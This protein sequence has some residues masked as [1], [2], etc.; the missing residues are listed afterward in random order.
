MRGWS[1]H[2]AGRRR[3]LPLEICDLHRWPLLRVALTHAADI[4]LVAQ[5]AAVA[6]P[7]SKAVLLTY[8]QPEANHNGGWLGFGKDGYLYVAAGDGGRGW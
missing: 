1:I 6:D 2:S 8:N 7:G 5:T 4:E 3:P